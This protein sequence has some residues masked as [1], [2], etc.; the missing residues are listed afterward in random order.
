VHSDHAFA[1]VAYLEVKDASFE[2]KPDHAL[3]QIA[4]PPLLDELALQIQEP[5]SELQ[6]QLSS[7]GAT[8]TIY[9]TAI[10]KPS[11]RVVGSWAYISDVQCDCSSIGSVEEEVITCFET[12][13]GMKTTVPV[14]VPTFTAFNT[15]SSY[16]KITCILNT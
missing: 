9:P 4:I 12:I 16:P 8:P 3:P 2:D 7:P 10:V 15:Q 6:E 5:C 1:T 11:I 13:K 14:P